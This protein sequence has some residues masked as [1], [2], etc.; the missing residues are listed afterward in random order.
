MVRKL[1]ITFFAAL[2]ML[3]TFAAKN[4]KT[5]QATQ[6]T[7]QLM[8]GLGKVNVTPTSMIPFHSQH[9]DYPYSA[10]HDSLYARAIV[11]DPGLQRAVLVDSTRLQYL[12]M[13][14]YS[15]R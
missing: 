3:P 7:G 9:E 13:K 2:A 10:V 12:T 14:M 15:E 4:K 11:M 5:T 6:K 8:I 1:L